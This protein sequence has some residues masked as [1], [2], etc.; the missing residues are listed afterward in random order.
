MLF[1]AHREEILNQ[2]ASTFARIR[3]SDRVGFYRGE[4]RDTEV[5]I[6]CASIQTL[7]KADHLEH[8]G[9]GRLR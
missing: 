8:F 3:P 4:E 2:A 6:L 7:G 1:V 9:E 5:D